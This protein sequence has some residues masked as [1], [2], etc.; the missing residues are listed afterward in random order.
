MALVVDTTCL[1]SFFLS[2]VALVLMHLVVLLMFVAQLSTSFSNPVS[3]MC[4]L[5]HIFIAYRLVISCLI[6]LVSSD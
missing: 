4:V 6:I 2:F 1:R 5:Y 3:R